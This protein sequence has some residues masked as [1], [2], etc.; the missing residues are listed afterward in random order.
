MKKLAK[1]TPAIV[2]PVAVAAVA[3]GGPAIAAGSSQ[4]TAESVEE[5]ISLV[6]SSADAQYS[7]EVTQSSDLGLPELP[8]TA[9]GMYR[10]AIDDPSEAIAEL[11][12]PHELRVFVGGPQQ[13]RVQVLDDLAERDVIRNGDEVWAWDSRENTAVQVTVPE[14]EGTPPTDVTRLTPAELAQRFLDNVTPSTDVTLDSGT[15][16]AGRNADLLVLDPQTDDTLVD[17]VA[18]AVD[19]ETGVPLRVSVEAS[20]VTAVEV[21]FTSIDYS[22]PDDSLFEFTPPAGAEVVTKTPSEGE[23]RERGDYPRPTVTGEDW[24]IIVESVA[25]AGALSGA[26]GE[27]AELLDQ[28]TTPVEGGR[29]V[30]TTLFSVLLTDDGRMLTGAVPLDALVAAAAS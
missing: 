11:T 23:D 24:T 17:S 5:L 13:Q 25:P 15:R 29:G 21:E 27:S 22:A 20:G 8:D 26:T 16:V 1:W 12:A 19:A 3:F 14:H 30:Q 6:E 2:A 4:P 9:N 18:I 10:G 28:L 7:G